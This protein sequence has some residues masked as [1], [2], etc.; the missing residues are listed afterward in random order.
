MIQ[1]L[2]EALGSKKS[3]EEIFA[4]YKALPNARPDIVQF[5]NKNSNLVRNYGAL[6]A[7]CNRIVR[8]AE[9]QG[10]IEKKKFTSEKKASKSDTSEAAKEDIPNSPSERKAKRLAKNSEK[11]KKDAEA[12]KQKAEEEAEE[13]VKDELTLFIDDMVDGEKKSSEEASS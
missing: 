6:I 9:Q 2:Y 3:V 10:K 12:A 4:I 7:E 11:A 8:I 5:Y 1:N 13:E